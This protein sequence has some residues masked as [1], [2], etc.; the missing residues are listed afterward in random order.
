MEIEEKKYLEAVKNGNTLSPKKNKV[1]CDYLYKQSAWEA[2]FKDF[3]A[4]EKEY[5]INHKGA[6]IDNTSSYVFIESPTP[7]FMHARG[8]SSSWQLRIGISN[9]GPS[10]RFIKIENCY[11]T[12]L[13][14]KLDDSKDRIHIIINLNSGN[15]ICDSYPI[16]MAAIKYTMP[17]VVNGLEF[18]C[19]N[20]SNL[21]MDLTNLT[22][23]CKSYEDSINLVDAYFSE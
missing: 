3:E 16:Q 18:L 8:L 7:T 13:L 11:H 1:L 19:Y 5:I 23:R 20:V 9:I 14:E 22:Q 15:L 10:R 4:I 12:L 6:S 21:K 2:I 17:Q